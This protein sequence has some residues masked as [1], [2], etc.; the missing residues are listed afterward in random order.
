MADPHSFENTL[1]IHDKAFYDW[2]GGLRVDYGDPA[3][4][5]TGSPNA[6]SYPTRNNFPILRTMA[7]RQRAFA[8]IVDL[9]VYH[10]WIDTGTATE[11]RQQADDFAVLPLP[12]ATIERG[13]P[14]PDP[15]ASS[16]P[17][18]FARSR[19][20]EETG[21]WEGHPWPATYFLPY[22][23]TFWTIKRYSEA[24]LR[25]WIHSKFGTLGAAESE[26]YLQVGHDAPWGV[27]LQSLRI[28]AT[29]DQSDLEGDNPRYIRYEAIFQLRMLHMRPLAAED[30]HDPISA[31][32]TPITFLQP[33]DGDTEDPLTRTADIACAPP[34]SGNLFTRYYTMARDIAAKWP[35]SGAATVTR[36]P[37]APPGGSIDH[38]LQTTVRAVAD[39]VGLAEKPVLIPDAPNNRALLSFSMRYRATE[40][41]TLL[42]SQKDGTT[43]P[44]WSDLRRIVLPA[45]TTWTDF[46]VFTLADEHIV[47]AVLEGRAISSTLQVTNIDMR[48]AFN[49]VALLPHGSSP[50]VGGTQ[51]TW[52]GLPQHQSYLLVVVPDTYSGS[53]LMRVQDDAN[54]PNDVLERMIDL[55]AERGFVE[56]VTPKSSSV[57]ITV[58]TGFPSAT[59]YL[60]PYTGGFLGRLLAA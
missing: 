12:V 50:G 38:T 59:F 28:E 39:R 17:K 42:L 58:P 44:A 31:V 10:G 25:E 6:S 16:V 29:A 34:I 2:L 36:S 41:A 30:I 1:R 8:T 51:W 48:H 21:K 37:I 43:P 20:N 18:R 11:I 13:D 22:T 9:L 47:S 14:V 33:G 7:T 35:K 23:V 26:T 49:G 15:I 24:F 52:A 32:D 53:W 55:T 46:Q 40:E 45:T 60:Q 4:L 54:S 57:S 27:Q 56:I 3:T 19:L 5:P